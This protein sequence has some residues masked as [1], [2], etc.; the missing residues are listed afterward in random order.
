M[1][2]LI[3]DKEEKSRAAIEQFV[4]QTTTLDLVKS[5]SEVDE[6]GALLLEEKVDVIL[7]GLKNGT[8]R[9]DLQFMNKVGHDPARM[10]VISDSSRHAQM[11][12]DCDAIDYL[13]R[14][15]AY[16]RFLKAVLKAKRL[17]HNSE[18]VPKNGHE[19]KVLFVKDNG[20]FVKI[21][22]DEISCISSAG[23]YAVIQTKEKKFIVHQTMKE[24]I[25]KL[26]E[27][28]FVR[29]HNSYI[30]NIDK[31]KFVEENSVTIDDQTTISI[32]RTYRKE[33]MDRL[34]ML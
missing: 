12:F 7:L 1:K 20:R 14:P 13:V 15:L 8:S 18:Q 2:C 29:I 16:D 34:Q 3:I 10:I 21:K 9:T 28:L 27:K 30:V 6:A 22:T 31:I 11:A 24:L 32:G 5:C 25:A 23:D 17:Q 4:S 26:P 19:S 33:L